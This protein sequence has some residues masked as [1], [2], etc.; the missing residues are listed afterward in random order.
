MRRLC[1]RGWCQSTEATAKG[2]EKLYTPPGHDYLPARQPA[3]LNA[4]AALHGR[5]KVLNPSGTHHPKLYVGRRGERIDAVI[6]S[7]N[8]SGGLYANIE[9]ATWLR[10]TTADPVL[11]DAWAWAESQWTDKRAKDWIIREVGPHEREVIAPELLVLIRRA[12]IPDVQT[13]PLALLVG[14]RPRFPN[15][16]RRR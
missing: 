6:G 2:L 7:A 9:V 10:G 15:R 1:K 3:A 5:V 14:E 12:A 11:N 16:H 8:L 4:V 13:L